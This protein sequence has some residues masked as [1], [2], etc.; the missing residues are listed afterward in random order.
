MSYSRSGIA[1]E[2]GDERKWVDMYMESISILD[3]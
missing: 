3:T 2:G 1:G